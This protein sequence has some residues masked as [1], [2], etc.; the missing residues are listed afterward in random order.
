MPT[1]V[2]LRTMRRTLT[3]LCLCLGIL[4]GFAVNP[5]GASAAP[6]R[7]TAVSWTASVFKALN[8][9]RAAH[10]LPQLGSSG[11]L[12]SIARL[13]NVKM[14]AYNRLSHQLP[15]E[16]TARTRIARAGFSASTAGE[17]LAQTTNWTLA[18]ALAQQHAMYVGPYAI[19]GRRA[20]ILNPGFRYVGV[21]VAIDPVHHKLWIT[22][23]FSVLPPALATPSTSTSTSS[24][25][26]EML[27]TMN[28]ERAANGRPA[29]RMN[30]ALI[31]SAHGHNVKMASANL[32][33]H[34]LGGE[35]G[36]LA[37]LLQ[38]GYRPRA[39]G[40][41][42]GWNSNRSVAGVL[43]LQRIMYNEV[44]PNDAH[45][46]NILSTTYREVGIDVYLDTA[47]N[48]LWMTQD[49]GLAA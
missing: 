46:V 37:R 22:Q 4:V 43:Y 41:N 28:A 17:N 42:I 14:A 31:R 30:A 21:D 11:R 7:A 34:L 44:P 36:F 40:E 20:N 19:S 25:A 23:D 18:G 12:T 3:T 38:V 1:S 29:L 39:A 33:S 10:H 9:E 15:G 16:L 47:H 27:K 26:A 6:S 48:K 35:L 45:R 32:M 13:H 2:A 5:G 8:V 24:M 49:F